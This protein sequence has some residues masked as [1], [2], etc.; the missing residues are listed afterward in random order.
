MRVCSCC[1]RS[2]PLEDFGRRGSEPNGRREC[3]R[4]NCANSLASRL[5]R[6]GRSNK[7]PEKTTSLLDG[8]ARRLAE[9]EA[10]LAA[11]PTDAVIKAFKHLGWPFRIRRKTVRPVC[12]PGQARKLLAALKSLKL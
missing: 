11:Y 4:C 5:K 3:R 6:G 2:L 1:K 7:A 10:E 12:G 8:S 9:V